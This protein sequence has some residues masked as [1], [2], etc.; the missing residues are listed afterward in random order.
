MSEVN[1]IAAK[2]DLIDFSVVIPSFR[3][4][5]ILETIE[6]VNTQNYERK[7]IQ[8][9]IK[10]GGS[11]EIL[12]GKIQ[13]ALQ[14]QDILVSD[15]DK[16]IF[17]GINRGLSLATGAVI[18]TI[19]SD[20]KFSSHEAVG[21]FMECFR[22]PDVQFVCSG[23][24]FTN[25]NW[26]LIRDWP[27]TLP[28]NANFLLGHQISHF[29]FA[30]R[31]EVYRANGNFDLRYDV[32]ADFDFFLRL[33]KRQLA[34]VKLSERLVYLK[35]GGNSSKNVRNMLRGN[36]QAFRSGLSHYGPLIL[37]HFMA[38]PF[39][40]GGQFLRVRLERNGSTRPRKT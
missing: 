29:G 10:D 27:A 6:S 20:D 7:R 4:V 36:Y 5:R 32:S 19:G 13:R 2:P 31:Q 11:D 35:L 9:V 40:K 3:D 26:D 38:K 15:R 22:N 16:G 8:I 24:G 17:D 18:F 39:V 23:V 28:T 14:P 21:Q 33:T 12:L 1:P 37:V 25:A 30:C 34:G